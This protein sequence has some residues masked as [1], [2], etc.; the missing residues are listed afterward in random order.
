MTFPNGLNGI[1]QIPEARALLFADDSQVT[2]SRV[3]TRGLV[4]LPFGEIK[5]LATAL[6]VSQTSGHARTNDNILAWNKLIISK[7]HSGLYLKYIFTKT[8]SL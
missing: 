1:M 3:P 7:E 4:L 6:P 8:N 2:S 5:A